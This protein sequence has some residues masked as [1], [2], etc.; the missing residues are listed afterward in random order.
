MSAETMAGFSAEH[1]E[2]KWRA[3]IAAAEESGIRLPVAPEFRR[4][5]GRVFAFS[6]FV[7]ENCVRHPALLADLARSGD[8][9]RDYPADAYGHALERVLE[10]LTTQAEIEKILRDFR[11]RELVRIAWRDLSGTSDLFVTMAELTALADAVIDR[12]LA[13]LYRRQCDAHGVPSAPDGS[14]QQLVVIGMG[15]LGGKELNFS[16][17][18]DLIFAYPQSGETAGGPVAVSNDEFFTRLCRRLLQVIGKV[19]ADGFVFRVD[20]RLRPFGD[21]GP[22][23]M[24]FDAMEHYY[25]QQG[26]EWERYAWIKARTVAGDRHGGESLL[27]RMNPFVYRRYL[28]F[29]AFESLRDMKQRITLEVDRREMADNIKLGRGGIREIEFFGQVFQL[30][31][32]GITPALQ[33]RGILKILS[34]LGEGRTV[35][36]SVCSALREAY[37]FLRILEHRLQ[38]FADKQTHRLPGNPLARHRLAASMGYDDPVEWERRLEDHRKTVHQHFSLL[39]QSGGSRET[40]AER[41]LSALWLGLLEESRR[42]DLLADLGYRPPA[43]AAQILEHLQADLA[44]RPLGKEGRQR[45]DKLMPLLLEKAGRGSDPLTTLARISGLIK[46]IDGRASYFALL[47]EN[48]AALDH[49][50]R[51]SS[52]SSLIAAFLTRH[53][54]LLDELLDP[55]TLYAPPGKED[56]DQDLR[57]RFEQL[58]DDL[59]YQMETLRIFKQ[60]NVLRVAAADVTEALPLMRVSDRLSDIATAVIEKVLELTWRHLVAKHG[61]PAAAAS[62][63]PAERGFAVVAY[64]KLGGLELG[65]GSDLDL[66]FLHSGTEGPTIGGPHPIDNRQFYARLGQRVIHILTSHTRAGILYETHMR[67]RPS[68]SSGILVSHIDGFRDYQLTEAWTWEHQALIRARAVG[69][70]MRLCRRFEKIRREVLGRRRD[71]D[72]LRAE[73]LEM[74]QRMRAELLQPQ[75]NVFDIKQDTGG[76]VDIEFLVQ[77]LVLRHAAAHPELLV[78]TDN[79]RLIH[80]LIDSGVVHEYDAH[81]L[82]HAYLIY[83]AVAHKLSLQEKT[84]CVPVDTFGRLRRKVEELWKLFIE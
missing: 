44:Q 9:E 42:D 75:E 21:D 24:S 8:L 13:L 16:S 56:L 68:G 60:V 22:L 71:P 73:V 37:I 7:F 26:R 69:G 43:S 78:W 36:P 6:D 50:V 2:N 25:H 46:A 79:V 1:A 65:Y 82:K 18:I 67:L 14:P 32:G 74:R 55:R 17:D 19:T 52:A 3:L 31:R 84:A 53:P 11:R 51:L 54:V 38:E 30:I 33:A 57:L 72:K 59:E 64:G 70:D 62:R 47:L 40:N 20:V 66:V 12:T 58:P 27:Q 80:T 83:R 61:R 10:G 76:I 34:I 28:D 49:L 81:L 39:L 5:A 4:S 29:G 63:A 41:D 77:Y 15:K 48:P 35:P 45:L 23:A